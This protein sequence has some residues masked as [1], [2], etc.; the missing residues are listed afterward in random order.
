MY[1]DPYEY[2]AKIITNGGIIAYATEA[3]W[4]FGCDPWNSSAVKKLLEL[5]QRPSQKGFILVVSNLMQIKPL[6][7]NFSLKEK[8][9]ISKSQSRATT[10]ILKDKSKWIPSFVKGDTNDVA[11]RISK[12]RGVEKL[13]LAFGGPVI[14]SSVNISGMPAL[15]KYEQ[16]VN[17]FGKQLDFIIPGD[18]GSDSRPSRIIEFTTGKIIR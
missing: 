12:H 4:G 17:S 8:Q 5:K 10:W 2:A 7:N 18:V 14:S 15:T 6:V 16:V 11:I 3:V 13:C 9:K 1:S